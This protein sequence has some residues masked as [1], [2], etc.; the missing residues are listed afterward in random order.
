MYVVPQGSSRNDII[1]INV[2]DELSTSVAEYAN[3]YN[4]NVGFMLLG[5]FN[6][7]TATE[8]DYVS[9]DNNVYLPL[10]DDYVSD[11]ELPVRVSKDQRKP[12]PNGWL[13]LFVNPALS[14][15]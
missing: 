14:V 12:T 10:P 13:L 3:L 6:A 11:I 8:V 9:H 4:E 5:D 1:D 2:F 7:R 15:F